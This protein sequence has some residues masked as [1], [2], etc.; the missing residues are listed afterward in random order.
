MT[1]TK[2]KLQEVKLRKKETQY[3]QFSQ[4]SKLIPTK[5]HRKLTPQVKLIST[6]RLVIKYHH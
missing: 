5:A 4:T 2:K 6:I 1:G 3:S